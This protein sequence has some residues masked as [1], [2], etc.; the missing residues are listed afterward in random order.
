MALFGYRLIESMYKG[1][2]IAILNSLMKG[3]TS[4]SLEE[5]YTEANRIMRKISFRTIIVFIIVSI[6]VYL[7]VFKKTVLLHFNLL[8]LYSFLLFSLLELFPA[9]TKY[10]GLHSVA[11][12]AYKEN[13][14]PDDTLVFRE[15]PLKQYKVSNF[16]GDKYSPVYHTVVPPLTIS[17]STNTDGFS[18]NSRTGS[19]DVDR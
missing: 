16:R 1:E 7:R 12:Y 11:Y 13:Y 10:L 18:H 5:Y 17:G 9:F 3:R 14:I 15:R 4:T 6:L 8:L 19:S 2:S